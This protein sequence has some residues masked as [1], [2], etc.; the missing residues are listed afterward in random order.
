V[1]ALEML[2]ERLK[3]RLDFLHV[4][5]WRSLW[6]V[7]QALIAGKQLWL[8]A[9]G[10][11]LPTA[12]HRKHAIKA[13]DRLLG[14]D[15]LYRERFAIA[16]ALAAIVIHRRTRPIVLVDT[17]EIRHRV[18]AITAALAHDGRSFPIWSTKVRH[19]R[20]RARDLRR[21]LDELGRVL[22]PACSPILVT[23]AGFETPWLCEVDRRGWD[24]VCRVRGQVHVLYKGEWV[25]L[26]R[27]RSLATG[28]AKNLGT[29]SLA[30][31]TPH[32]RRVVLSKLP[33]CRHRQVATRR[34][35]ARG[36]NYRV[37]RQ[38]AY[39]PLVVTTSLTSHPAQVI[40]LYRLRMQ[41][42]QSFRDLKNHRWGW[43]LRHC[44]T[45]SRR[46]IELLLLIAA[47][48]IVA[49]QLAGTAAENLGLHRYHQANTIQRRRVL[50]LFLL[51][52]LTLNAPAGGRGLLRRDLLYALSCLRSR[53]ATLP[54]PSS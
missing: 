2:H 48:A 54:P 46:R 4:A 19:Y 3:C 21:F 41:I 53:I 30:R 9:L 39:E 31:K 26:E 51:G 14:N 12:A 28:R 6:R 16:A 32:A 27:I 8:T 52:G 15:H 1:R 35:P 42:E 25:G 45:R 36:T 44:L 18:V 7:V 11:S 29:L 20:P 24:Y 47:I 33:I 23:D 17:V 40:A 13:V 37:Y 50:S 22:P 38:N 49:Q 10:R 43:S 5:R 34:G